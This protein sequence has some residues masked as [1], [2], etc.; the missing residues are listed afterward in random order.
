MLEANAFRNMM[1]IGGVVVVAIVIACF[2]KAPLVPLDEQ[3]KT[4]Y[5]NVMHADLGDA[6]SLTGYQA[7]LFTIQGKTRG[8]VEHY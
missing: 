6:D 1:L 4:N 2:F 8:A 5:E 7:V 3:A